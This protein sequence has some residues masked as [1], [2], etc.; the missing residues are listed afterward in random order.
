M[1]LYQK[2][3]SLSRKR[4]IAIA[5]WGVH[6][7]IVCFLFA[8]YSLSHRLQPAK[9]ISVRTIVPQ[10]VA[11]VSTVSKKS[12]APV[13]KN[14]PAPKKESSKKPTVL[15]EKKQEAVILKDIVN[16]LDVLTQDKPL[17]SETKPLP[18]VPSLPVV[19]NESK[20]S[21]SAREDYGKFLIGYFQENLDLPEYGDVKAQIEIDKFGKLIRYEVLETKSLKNAEFL[22]NALP[23]LTFPCLN[24]FGIFETAQ[25]FTITFRN[26]ETR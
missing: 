25:T 6:F 8:N 24:D 2:F 14:A 23:E 5:V 9:K 19:K 7:G 21:S 4:Q 16:R 18:K 1:K 20:K 13:K 15:K 22:K 26:V 11:K 10:E 3:K 12:P 17:K